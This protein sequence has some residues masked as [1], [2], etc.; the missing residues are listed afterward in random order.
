M[1]GKNVVFCKGWKIV[2]MTKDTLLFMCGSIKTKLGWDK[3]DSDV[4]T[5]W[6]K[7]VFVYCHHVDVSGYRTLG[8][9]ELK[10]LQGI[11]SHLI[12]KTNLWLFS[13]PVFIFKQRNSHFLDCNT[14]L[15]L[16]RDMGCV[17]HMFIGWFSQQQQQCCSLSVSKDKLM[18]LNC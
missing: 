1:K 6:W 10:S 7:D 5:I 17:W 14:P 4:I 9:S 18:Q 3:C 13:P 11:I 2:C 15:S 8:F 12:T 16:L